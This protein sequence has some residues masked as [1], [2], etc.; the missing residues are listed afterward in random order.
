MNLEEAI[1]SVRRHRQLALE[2][3]RISGHESDYSFVVRCNL[4]LALA[5]PGVRWG[6]QD[7]L[8]YVSE[9]R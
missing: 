3:Y 1:A 9:P 7:D 5:M 4:P 8:D 2:E 6:F